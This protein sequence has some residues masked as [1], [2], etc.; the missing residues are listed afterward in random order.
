MEM[1]NPGS[2]GVPPANESVHRCCHEPA[3]RRRPQEC[4]VE[5]Q[6]SAGFERQAKA[7]TPASLASRL[8]LPI[9]DTR[10][11]PAAFSAPT[12]ASRC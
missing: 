7:W 2:A 4:G 5:V 6:A 1:T 11:A 3:R 9:E 8:P 10:P 12:S